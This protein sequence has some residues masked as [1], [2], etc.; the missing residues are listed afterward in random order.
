M[1]GA[2]RPAAGPRRELSTR[3]VSTA[4]YSGGPHRGGPPPGGRHPGDRPYDPRYPQGRRSGTEPA[5]ARSALGLRA[6]L[7]GF[8]LVMGL[9]VAIGCSLVAT[10]VAHPT[11]LAVL[12]ALGAAW[13]LTAVVDLLVIARRRREERAER[14]Q[15]KRAGRAGRRRSRPWPGPGGPDGR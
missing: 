8:G 3:G 11:T 2:E 7:A 14:A 12:A 5:T 6:A 1:T 10:R 13:A 4:R 15:A 9:A